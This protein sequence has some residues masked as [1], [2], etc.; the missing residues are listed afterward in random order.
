MGLIPTVYAIHHFAV[1]RETKP[2][3]AYEKLNQYWDS[4]IYQ[5]TPVTSGNF[6]PFGHKKLKVNRFVNYGKQVRASLAPRLQSTREW[7]NKAVEDVGPIANNWLIKTQNGIMLANKNIHM[8]FH[9]TSRFTTN[10]YHNIKD[11]ATR[12]ST[13]ASMYGRLGMDYASRNGRIFAGNLSKYT[14]TSI[15]T[16]D[17]WLHASSVGA[18]VFYKTSAKSFSKHKKITS[19]ILKRFGRKCARVG[20]YGLRRSSRYSRRAFKKLVRLYPGWRRKV[21]SQ[22]LA[23]SKRGAL[24]W[25]KDSFFGKQIKSLSRLVFKK[26]TEFAKTFRGVCDENGLE[27]L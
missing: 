5:E 11:F 1:N 4:F 16:M 26:Y 2:V 10:E 25:S 12:G 7:A 18:A 27:V 14:R 13:M 19:I 9:E 15:D 22:V 6:F 8:W 23:W 24:F 20:K 3:T 17:D 21:E